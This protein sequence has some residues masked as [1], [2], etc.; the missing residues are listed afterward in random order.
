ME[1]QDSQKAVL[2]YAIPIADNQTRMAEAMGALGTQNQ[3]IAA[4]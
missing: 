2:H 4:I 1:E 3:A